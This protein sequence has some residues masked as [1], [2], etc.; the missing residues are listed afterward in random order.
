MGSF[1]RGYGYRFDIGE[2][3][4][5]AVK[6]LCIIC[7]A[8]FFLQEMSL[9]IWKADGWAFWADWFGL[10]PALVTKGYVWQPFTYLFLHEGFL[11]IL[12]NLL[13]LAMFGADLEHMWGTRKFYVYF[14]LCGVGAGLI[15]VIVRTILDP[16]AMGRALN[17]TVGASGAIYG[18]LLA[19][20]ILLPQR[21]VWMFPLPV[22]VSMR[23]FVIIMGAAEFFFTIGTAD[24]VSHFCHLGGML[25]GYIYLRRG[26]FLYN[27]RNFFSDWKR[28][29]LRK[30][31]EVYVRDHDD[32]PP[33]RPDNWVN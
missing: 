22:T 26:S 25:V 9:F 3:F 2:Y 11:H 15:D 32:K 23:I 10:V 8:V 6:T 12:F 24:N 21:R 33:S 29:R 30:K 28:R 31:F 13:Y 4:P 5:R 18:I 16:H 14:F 1:S 17:P 7:I 20:A 27:Y 19:N